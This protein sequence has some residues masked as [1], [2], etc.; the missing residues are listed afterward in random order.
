MQ[1][2]FGNAA[3]FGE[4]SDEPLYVSKVMQKAMVEVNEEGSEAAAATG[5]EVIKN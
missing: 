1:D 2:M 5:N 4:M 3:N